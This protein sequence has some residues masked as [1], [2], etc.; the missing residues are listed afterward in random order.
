MKIIEVNDSYRDDWLRLRQHVYTGVDTTFL[1]KEMASISSSKI[2]SCFVI[3][4]KA[5]GVIGFMELSLRNIVDGVIGGP[6]GYIEGLYVDPGY[7]GNGY[8]RCLI[9]RA[10]EWFKSKNCQYIATDTELT[11]DAAQRYFE[12]LGFNKTWTVVQYL[13]ALS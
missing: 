1:E 9:D 2:F 10:T 11:N 6:V 5:T 4:I 7:R 13:K 12:H 3:E 8:G